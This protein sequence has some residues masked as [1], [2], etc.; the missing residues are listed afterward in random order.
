[1]L[2]QW[3]DDCTNAEYQSLLNADGAE[4]RRAML[5]WG[6]TAGA[7][8]AQL[9][10]DVDDATLKELLM[11]LGGHDISQILQAFTAAAKVRTARSPSWPTPLKAGG[12]PLLVTLTIM[13]PNLPRRIL[14]LCRSALVLP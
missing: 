9:L 4:I 7:D 12:C 3:I 1:W 8:M 6:A 10:T 2:Q 5:E 13:P 11:N 14:R